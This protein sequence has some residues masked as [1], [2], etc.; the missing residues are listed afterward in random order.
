MIAIGPQFQGDGFYS[1]PLPSPTGNPS[2][3]ASS[4]A[5]IPRFKRSQTK[6]VRSKNRLRQISHVW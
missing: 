1:R 5:R 6:G 4:K 3:R 2:R